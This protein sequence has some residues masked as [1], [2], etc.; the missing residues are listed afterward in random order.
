MWDNKSAETKRNLDSTKSLLNKEALELLSEGA[1]DKSNRIWKHPVRQI[2]IK[3]NQKEFGSAKDKRTLAEYYSG[4][5]E[6]IEG[7]YVKELSGECVE[8]TAKGYKEADTM[9]NNQ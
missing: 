7:K 8:L 6:L 5:D 4:L 2:P 9:N 1:K 3:T